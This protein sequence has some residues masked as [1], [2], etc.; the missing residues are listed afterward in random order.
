MR[1]RPR[2]SNKVA[3]CV[4][5]A[6]REPTRKRKGKVSM[7][8]SA[9]VQAHKQERRHANAPTTEQQSCEGPQRPVDVGAGRTETKCR[10]GKREPAR[11]T[12]IR[13]CVYVINQ[14]MATPKR[15][16]ESE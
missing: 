8:I 2:P 5:S 7:R 13:R 14:T 16:P 4:G 1:T 12:M 9:C 10:R 15:V 11:A 6:K 3:R